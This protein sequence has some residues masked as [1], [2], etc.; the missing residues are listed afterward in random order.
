[1]NGDWTPVPAPASHP[2]KCPRSP[3]WSLRLVFAEYNTIER[4]R[5]T[6]ANRAMKTAVGP[7]MS[8]QSQI[9]RIHPVA[10]MGLQSSNRQTPGTIFAEL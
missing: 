9:P 10:A 4:E 6:T 3:D 1:M 2:R 8:R 7:G 5:R